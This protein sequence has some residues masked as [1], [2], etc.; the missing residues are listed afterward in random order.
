MLADPANKKIR[1]A[2]ENEIAFERRNSENIDKA[3][4][5]VIYNYRGG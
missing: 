5:N 3:L 2:I 4:H 1:K